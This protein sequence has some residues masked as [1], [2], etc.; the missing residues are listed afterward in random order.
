M[1]LYSSDSVARIWIYEK[2]KEFAEYFENLYRWILLSLTTYSLS[3]DVDTYALFSQA[4][5]F[6][7]WDYFDENWNLK[8]W[9]DIEF[10]KEQKLK[11]FYNEQISKQKINWKTIKE[12]WNSEKSEEKDLALQASKTILTTI[13]EQSMLTKDNKWKITNIHIWWNRFD[14]NTNDW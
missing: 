8:D 1:L 9:L 2:Y 12:L 10:L 7:N 13:L 3:N 5:A 11:D 14:S 6:W 4:L